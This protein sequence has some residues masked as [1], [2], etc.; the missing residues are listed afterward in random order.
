MRCLFSTRRDL[1]GSI[2]VY[3][4]SIDV[5]DWHVQ[6]LSSSYRELETCDVI[7]SSDGLLCAEDHKYKLRCQK[8]NAG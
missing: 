1:L 6:V 2:L 8:L 5:I 4:K 3:R 7:T